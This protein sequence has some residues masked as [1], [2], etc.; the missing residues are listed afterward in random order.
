MSKYIDITGQRFGRLTATFRIKDKGQTKWHCICDCGRSISAFLSNLGRSTLSCG[1]LR[2]EK[3][4]ITHTKHGESNK[5]IT[6]EYRAWENMKRRCD[7]P[8]GNRFKN[9]GGR[10]ISVCTE[11]LLSYD[12]FSTDMGKRPTIHHS[13]DRKDVNGNY[14]KDNCR[15]ATREEQQAN[16]TRNTFYTFLGKRLIRNE[17]IKRFDICDSS[18]INKIKKHSFEEIAQKHLLPEYRNLVF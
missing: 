16:T 5:E 12:S 14:C 6:A 4:I 10:G 11:W 3:I 18:F 9:Y 17:W 1:C 15:W 7:N 8:S 13:L 2:K